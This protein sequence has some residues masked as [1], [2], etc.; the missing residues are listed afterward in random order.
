VSTPQLKVGQPEEWQR[1][2]NRVPRFVEEIPNLYSLA[3]AV[4]ERGMPP[5]K[6]D[7]VIEGLG[8]LVWED[9]EEIV[10]LAANGHGLPT[11][12]V[13]RGSRVINGLRKATCHP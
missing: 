9:F 5:T 7:L 10:T 6:D 4:F 3:R 12:Q 11:S 2:S 8:L 13:L 1:F